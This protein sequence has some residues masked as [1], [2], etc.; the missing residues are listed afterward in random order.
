MNIDSENTRRYDRLKNNFFKEYSTE[1]SC[2]DEYVERDYRELAQKM[3]AIKKPALLLFEGVFDDMMSGACSEEE[4]HKKLQ[5]F[6]E[7]FCFLESAYENLL[8]TVDQ[9]IKVVSGEEALDPEQQEI[10]T[11]P[12]SNKEFRLQIMGSAEKYIK[13][14][15]GL[16]LG[17]LS[18]LIEVPSTSSTKKQ[19]AA[20]VK[21]SPEARD[22]YREL[23]GSDKFPSAQIIHSSLRQNLEINSARVPMEYMKNAKE[24]QDF[25]REQVR[26]FVK[27]PDI[28]KLLPRK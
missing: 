5:A 3:E 14:G 23:N 1:Y 7:P 15:A 25:A 21:L 17:D 24:Y 11:A 10:S 19:F 2:M 27:R 6:L 28:Q 12:K 8:Y 4:G 18:H 26:K 16:D 13:S 22:Q 20:H 9:L